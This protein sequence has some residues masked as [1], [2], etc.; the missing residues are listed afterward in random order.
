MPSN[1]FNNQFFLVKT[2]SVHYLAL[3]F[4]HEKIKVYTIITLKIGTG[5]RVTSYQKKWRKSLMNKKKE[6]VL[7]VGTYRDL[8]F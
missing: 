3:L 8:S 7:N 4:L 6:G 2:C 5:R 1:Y